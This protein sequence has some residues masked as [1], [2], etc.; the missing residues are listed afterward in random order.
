MIDLLLILILILIIYYKIGNIIKMV[1]KLLTEG[2]TILTILL[3]NLTWDDG[4][5]GLL[6]TFSTRCEKS[7]SSE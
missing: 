6:G 3:G 4:N 1:P 2:T 5:K 7:L